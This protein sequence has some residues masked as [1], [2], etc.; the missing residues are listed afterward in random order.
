MGL[1]R[2]LYCVGCCWLLMALSLVVGVMN[3]AWCAALAAVVPA[4]RIL[5]G[6]H[7]LARAISVVLALS[8]AGL[9]A[10]IL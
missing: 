3:A 4:E 8:G 2:G 10:G 9:A 7:R 5:P 6:G 1:R